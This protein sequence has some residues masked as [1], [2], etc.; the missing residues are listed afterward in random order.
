MHSAASKGLNRMNDEVENK[1]LECAKDAFDEVEG[2][3]GGADATG[4]SDDHRL[5]F[6]QAY[7]MGFNECHE[8]VVGFLNR[9][10]K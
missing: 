6:I 9:K 8:A 5:L 10:E 7:S 3:L 4:W 1:L 2:R